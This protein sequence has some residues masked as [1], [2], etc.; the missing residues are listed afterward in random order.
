M[1]PYLTLL[2]LL[3]IAN[4]LCAQIQFGVKAGF[5]VALDNA[6][7]AY[8]EANNRGISHGVT[9]Q[10]RTASPSIGLYTISD[11][12]L[13]FFQAEG[14]YNQ[15]STSY[16]VDSYI[17]DEIDGF[18][19]QE[20]YQNVNL[21]VLSGVKLNNWRIGVGPSFQFNLDMTTDL[22]ELSFYSD[23]SRS[24]SQGFQA[25]IA[26]D[27]GNIQLDLRYRTEFNRVGDHIYFTEDESAFSGKVRGLA[28]HAGFGF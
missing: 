8:V 24:L 23:K 28:L 18:T 11:M 12:G 7:T 26:Y 15:Y 14:L 2:T 21:N 22:T 19:L 9:Y 27:F 25:L 3:F 5:N 16:V 17:N 4:N 1:H 20:E 13:I 10:G 6:E